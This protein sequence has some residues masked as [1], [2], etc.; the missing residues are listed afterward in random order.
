MDRK[1]IIQAFAQIGARARVGPTPWPDYAHATS[2]VEVRVAHDGQG[3][4]FD[5]RVHPHTAVTR[6]ETFV[7][8]RE[9]SVLLQVET[10]GDTHRVRCGRDGD[11]LIVTPLEMVEAVMN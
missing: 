7:D 3:A 6:V 1:Q 10:L 2:P 5:V 11:A 9:P 8:P 4:Y